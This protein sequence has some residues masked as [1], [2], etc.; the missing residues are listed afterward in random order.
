MGLRYET[1]A[2]QMRSVL[3]GVSNLL[4]QHP[5]V[6]R[7]SVRVRFL[8]FGACSLD[9]E[10]FAYFFARDWSHFLG[11]QGELLLQIMEIVQT[12][13][14]QMAVQARTFVSGHFFPLRRNQCAGFVPDTRSGQETN[15]AKGNSA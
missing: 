7:D 10:I 3:E 12:T 6:E 11:I 14:A 9:V 13:G 2:S 5:R 1:T 4:E 15:E 8:R